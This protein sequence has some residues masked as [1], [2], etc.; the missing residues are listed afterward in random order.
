MEFGKD[1]RN[2]YLT[3]RYRKLSIELFRLGIATLFWA[4][5]MMRR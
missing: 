1:P 2:L 5:M 4:G 3:E